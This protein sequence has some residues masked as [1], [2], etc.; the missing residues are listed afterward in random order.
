M[1][2]AGI[3]RL[4]ELLP[5]PLAD[6]GQAPMLSLLEKQEKVLKARLALRPEVSGRL[7]GRRALEG[8][9]SRLK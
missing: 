1:A 6:A 2:S 5:H 7:E 4:T 8:R 9:W 3:G